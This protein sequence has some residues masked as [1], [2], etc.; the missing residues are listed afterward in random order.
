M[1]K[2]G[3]AGT[4]PDMTSGRYT[5]SDSTEGSIDRYG[6]D[7]DWGVLD[8]GAHSRHLANTIAPSVCGGDAALSQILK[9][10]ISP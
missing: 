8:G 10:F 5:Q 6:A 1:T 3:G 2:R 9:I 7:P 4:G